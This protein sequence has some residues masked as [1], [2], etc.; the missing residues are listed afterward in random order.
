MKKEIDASLSVLKSFK[1]KSVAITGA[2]GFIGKVLVEKLL[3]DVSGLKNIFILIR[4]K[5]EK[6]VEERFELLKS[7]PVFQRIHSECPQAFNKLIPIEADINDTNSFGISQLNMK[8]LKTEVSFVFHLAA[9]VKFTEPLEIAI[10][11]ILIATRT[12]LDIA[13]TFK[14]LEAFV[15]VSTA[16]SNV[17]VKKIGEVIHESEFTWH[18]AVQAVEKNDREKLNLLNIKLQRSFPNTYTFSKHLAEK[19]ILEKSPEMPLVIFRPS[20]VTTTLSEPFPGWVDFRGTCMGIHIGVFYG[21]LRCVYVDQDN[22]LSLVPC[23]VV[24]NGAILSATS[25]E[26]NQ[27]KSLK[28]Y[29]CTPDWGKIRIVDC[30]ENCLINSRELFPSEKVI[31][32]PEC[33]PIANFVS[34]I[35]YFTVFQRLPSL[36]F[37]M[38]MWPCTREFKLS[39]TSQKIYQYL[40]DLEYFT[41]DQSEFS[42][43][44]CQKLY[45]NIQKNE[46]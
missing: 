2:T 29:N 14:H 10:R 4:A 31:F 19:L 28:I 46:R 24:A 45:Q 6:T 8:K 13:Q 7:S 15:Y 37:D 17:H 11:T 20:I 21:V 33:V 23:D 36:I 12:L 34:F 1:D 41:I 40:V 22:I 30:V 26:Q 3:R 25:M 35:I 9:T 18:E 16:F 42:D 5:R 44:E 27:N 32:Y 43:T 38:I 39:R